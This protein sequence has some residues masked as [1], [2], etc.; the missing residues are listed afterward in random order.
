MKSRTCFRIAYLCISIAT[1]L[2]FLPLQ[3][4]SQEPL[5][6]HT[7]DEHLQ[8]GEKNRNAAK[9]G[10]ESINIA[11]FKSYLSYR[12]I[13]R[14]SPIT[15]EAIQER[16]DEMIVC[17]ILYQEALRHN[18][19]RDPKIRRQIQ[20]TLGQKLLED[21]ID[22]EVWARPIEEKELQAYYDRHKYEFDH[23]EQ[24]RLADI[25]IEVAPNSTP[26]Q[27]SE[28]E[29]KAES[30]LAYALKVRD[31][32][33][34]FGKL[35]RKYSD[36][37]HKYPLGDTGYLDAKGGPHGLHIKLAE[38][39]FKLKRSGDLCDHVIETPDG[40]HVIMLVGRRPALRKSLNSVKAEIKQQIRREEMRKARQDYIE[41]LREKADIHID[42]QVIAEILE[43]LREA[44]KEQPQTVKKRVPPRPKN[45]GNPPPVPG[46]GH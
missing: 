26:K 30:A 17:E 42:G 9:I 21:N 41:G 8:N 5:D 46:R 28:R 12:P 32:R 13:P 27:R 7:V 16:L 37:H 38:G 3:G 11:D 31:K 29:K 10:N 44:R 19:H 45:N 23:P 4:L 20:Q 6:T 33:F 1:I 36:T 15:E 22:R 43:E 35:I 40:Y 14:H 34:G 2:L 24:V 39:A 25:F 18:L